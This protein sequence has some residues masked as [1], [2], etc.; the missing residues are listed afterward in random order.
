LE[1]ICPKKEL[2]LICP[3]ETKVDLFYFND[4]P[5]LPSPPFL[6]NKLVTIVEK[7]TLANLKC[8]YKSQVFRRI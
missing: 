3:N 4:K 6:K 5:N 8:M 2:V 1:K 7:E